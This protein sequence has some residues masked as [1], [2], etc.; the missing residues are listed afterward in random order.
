MVSYSVMHMAMEGR[1]DGVKN[2]ENSLTLFMNSP[3][4]QLVNSILFSVGTKFKLRFIS[5][6][7]VKF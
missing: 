5:D 7:T 4:V 3:Q 1:D 6:F 2:P